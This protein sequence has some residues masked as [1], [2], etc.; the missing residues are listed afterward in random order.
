MFSIAPKIFA[1]DDGFADCPGIYILS[2]WQ[3]VWREQ[4]LDN[5]D[6]SVIDAH[7]PGPRCPQSIRLS[8]D[9]PQK[10]ALVAVHKP[11]KHV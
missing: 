10:L 6:R 8:P 11:P 4:K 2:L 7:V 1:F 3:R 9:V 5:G